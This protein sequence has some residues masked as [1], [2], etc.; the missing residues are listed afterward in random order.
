MHIKTDVSPVSGLAAF[1]PV[2]FRQFWK[3]RR[4][5]C[6]EGVWVLIFFHRHFNQVDRMLVPVASVEMALFEDV[7]G[8]LVFAQRLVPSIALKTEVFQWCIRVEGSLSL[9]SLLSVFLP[10]VMFFF[11]FLFDLGVLTGSWVSAS[12][13]VIWTG[14]IIIM[15]DE[16]LIDARWPGNSCS[17]LWCS[18]Q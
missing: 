18:R 9:E 10:L 6:R 14:V 3:L 1:L 11:P 4:K 7:L 12:H 5:V 2:D 8:E 17:T 15:S 13:V 16:E